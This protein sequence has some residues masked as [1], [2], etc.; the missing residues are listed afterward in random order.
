MS[1]KTMVTFLAGLVVGLVVASAGW[2]P[3]A[4][5]QRDEK[6]PQ[7]EYKV[8]RYPAASNEEKIVGSMN[9]LGQAGWEYAGEVVPT[10]DYT[11]VACRRAKH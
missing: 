10:Q 4:L 9:E 6:P 3:Q 1:G 8:V 11:Y 5:G 2:R 7:W